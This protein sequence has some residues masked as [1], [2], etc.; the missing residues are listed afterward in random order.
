MRSDKDLRLWN[1]LFN[2]NDKISIWITH[3][4]VLNEKRNNE[5]LQD[6]VMRYAKHKEA[7]KNRVKF[8]KL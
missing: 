4:A 5:L 1:L 3:Y 6:L 8:M 7:G 2:D